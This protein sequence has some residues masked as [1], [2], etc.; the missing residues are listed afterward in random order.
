[1]LR[2]Q[3][4]HH[5]HSASYKLFHHIYMPI[6]CISDPPQPKHTILDKIFTQFSHENKTNQHVFFPN[7]HS[8]THQNR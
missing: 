2:T 7:I 6:F 5:V 3:H 8:E 1:M 4:E